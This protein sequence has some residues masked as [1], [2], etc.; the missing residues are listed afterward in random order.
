[1]DDVIDPLEK[2]R[3]VLKMSVSDPW[4]R[5]FAIGGVSGEL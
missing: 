3:R 5:Y 1:V 2:A 4:W